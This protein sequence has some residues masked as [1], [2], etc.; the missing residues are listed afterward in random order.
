MQNVLQVTF[1]YFTNFPCCVSHLPA[2]FPPHDFPDTSLCI[3]KLRSHSVWNVRPK[4]KAHY[5]KYILKR[6]IIQMLFMYLTIG[7]R[8]GVIQFEK[9]GSDDD[10]SRRRRGDVG[11]DVRGRAVAPPPRGGATGSIW[12][13]SLP[14][15]GCRSLHA[16]G[17]VGDFTEKG[18]GMQSGK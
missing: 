2:S 12:R 16:R 17:A 10:P 15:C 18:R 7:S 1:L 6:N 9:Q 3:S 14:V 8:R 5:A 13:I 4:R 11:T